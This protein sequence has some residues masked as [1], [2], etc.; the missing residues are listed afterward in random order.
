MVMLPLTLGDPLSTLN[1]LNLYILHCLMHL[2]NWW[3]QRVQI[4]CKSWMC[5]WQPTED[6]LSLIWAWSGHVTHYK[7]LAPIISLERL[8]LKSSYF[9]YG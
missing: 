6:K 1:H 3:S 5:K 4:W 8:N 2:R 9:V 7:I